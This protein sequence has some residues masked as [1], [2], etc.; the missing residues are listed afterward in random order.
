MGAMANKVMMKQFVLTMIVVVLDILVQTMVQ[1]NNPLFFSVSLSQSTPPSL[2]PFPFPH[3]HPIISLSPHND[4]AR[5]RGNYRSKIKNSTPKENKNRGPINTHHHEEKE[6][7]KYSKLEEAKKIHV[8]KS[9]MKRPKRRNK[10]RV[11]IPW[12]GQNIMNV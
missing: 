12:S 10:V 2:T 1:A 9:V 8:R 6:N 5:S 3:P 4:S 7:I 11:G